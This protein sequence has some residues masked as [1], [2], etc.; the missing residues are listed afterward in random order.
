MQSRKNNRWLSVVKRRQLF[1]FKYL[2]HY[3]TSSTVTTQKKTFGVTRRRQRREY[4]VLITSKSGQDVLILSLQPCARYS[5][6][7]A[8][9][10]YDYWCF[11]RDTTTNDD[12]IVWRWDERLEE[13]RWHGTIWD[14]V[15][16]DD[17][18][19][20]ERRWKK[21]WND[22][23]WEVIKCGDMTRNDATVIHC[24]MGE[25]QG[26]QNIEVETT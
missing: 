4:P 1:R 25:I 21:R 20:H 14:K 9:L 24:Q 7:S 10:D 22:T 23:R 18:S 5:G 16:G 11:H 6:Q 8:V 3:V 12:W 19:W 15:W 13:M 26:L 17:M 2:A